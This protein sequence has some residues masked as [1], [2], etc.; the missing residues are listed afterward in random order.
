MRSSEVSILVSLSGVPVLSLPVEFP[1]VEERQDLP[2][3]EPR[4]ATE[5]CH[6]H[7]CLFF[8]TARPSVSLSLWAG[9]MARRGEN[10]P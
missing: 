10:T 7:W 9:S 1:Q 4:N 8:T 2:V 5:D 6:D 3:F